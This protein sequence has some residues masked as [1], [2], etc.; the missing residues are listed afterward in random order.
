MA[1]AERL[2][3]QLVELRQS[4][5][6][7]FSDP[8]SAGAPERENLLAIRLGSDPYA[9][10]LSEVAAIGS[11]RP[12]TPL[13]S[14]RPELLGI[15]GLRGVIVAVYDLAA[16]LGKPASD[17][18][19]WLA[20]AKGSLTAFAFSNFEGQ[21]QLSL[22]AVVRAQDPGQRALFEVARDA[23]VSRPLIH[24]PALILALDGRPGRAGKAG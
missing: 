5:D 14:D 20:L 13:P 2:Q 24:L 12:L 7:S 6:R 17:T 9:L 22:D 4:F 15:A 18:P 16:L 19:R 8:V 11:D 3:G 21:L 10:R 23:G 1:S